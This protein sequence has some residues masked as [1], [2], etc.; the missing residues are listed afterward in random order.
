MVVLLFTVL[1]RTTPWA[2]QAGRSSAQASQVVVQALPAHSPGGSRVL[3]GMHSGHPSPPVEHGNTEE[4]AN[5]ATQ[6][7]AHILELP[8]TGTSSLLRED[9]NASQHHTSRTPSGLFIS[10]AS[11]GEVRAL[12]S[13]TPGGSSIQAAQENRGPS[14]PSATLVLVGGNYGLPLIPTQAFHVP[15]F[16]V[17]DI[18]QHQSAMVEHRKFPTGKSVCNPSQLHNQETPTRQP[19]LQKTLPDSYTIATTYLLPKL[20]VFSLCTYEATKG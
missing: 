19:Q 12:P 16:Y 8:V 9:C 14:N 1:Q 13:H 2:P 15:A 3:S 5:L 7:A 18:P 10:S 11:Q 4:Q 17:G 20:P 6:A